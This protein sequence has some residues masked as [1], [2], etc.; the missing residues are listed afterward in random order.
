LLT[1]D[2]TSLTVPAGSLFFAN[3]GGRGYYRSAY[4]TD[5]YAELVKQMETGLK[6]TERV[7]LIGDEWAQVRSNKAT[8]G[9][10][11]ELAEA[12]KA[13]ENAE[14]ISTTLGSVNAIY[15][16]VAS[17]PDERDAISAWLRKNFAPAYAKL[18]PSTPEESPNNRE[19]RAEL[20]QEL[21]FYA[22]DPNVLAQSKE[23]AEKYLSDP[24]SVD[25]TLGQTALSVAARN[26]DA[27]LFDKLQQVYETSHVPE[28]QDGALRLLAF[29]E[30]PDL[31]NRA[32]EFA[33]SGKVRNQDAAI[34]FAIAL[35][36]PA[37]RD[38]AWKFIQ[39]HWDA[40]HA[41]L[42]PEMGGALVGSTS[43]FCSEQA[44]DDVQQFF[45]A[46]KVASADQAVKHSVE[47]INGCIEFRNLQ[48]GNLKTWL[49]SQGPASGQ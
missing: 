39:A 42:T 10:F 23:I 22:K 8:V 18:G 47:R 2:T 15:Q 21:G 41:L 25:P 6:P 20:F 4:P 36:Q 27:E 37:T 33:I 44:R 7:N 5:K 3:A 26:G 29:F 12:V 45:A 14:V 40:I 19:L 34:Q 43:G 16:R 49:G 28:L 9:D 38:L 24:S 35:N 31:A 17:T 13:D 11:L 1:P 48:Q 30:N 32:M 46:H